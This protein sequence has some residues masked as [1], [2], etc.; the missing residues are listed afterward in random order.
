MPRMVRS[1]SMMAVPWLVRS[2]VR[3]SPG[4]AASTA[5]WRR[6]PLGPAS[7]FRT[8]QAVG[9]AAAA[10]AASAITRAVATKGPDRSLQGWCS[11]APRVVRHGALATARSS[12]RRGC[13]RDV[14]ATGDADEDAAAGVVEAAAESRHAVFAGYR[15]VLAD[16]AGAGHRDGALVENPAAGARG[17][18]DTARRRSGCDG[19]WP[20]RSGSGCRCCGRPHPGR[21][22]H[23]GQ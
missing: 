9:E 13:C 14:A 4:S 7:R 22:R 23:R 5:F 2:S 3:R 17:P 1:L 18:E 20:S 11:P 21:W 15:L 10:V 6:A 12:S 16:A 19:C 8:R